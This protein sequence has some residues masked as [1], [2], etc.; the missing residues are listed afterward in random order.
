M[1]YLTYRKLISILRWADHCCRDKDFN[2]TKWDANLYFDIISE[3]K[4]I[5]R[6]E[7]LNNKN[8]KICQMN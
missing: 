6:Q 2:Y 5:K 3:A 1:K 4:E 7:Y 8:K